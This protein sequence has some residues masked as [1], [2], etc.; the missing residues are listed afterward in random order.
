MPI[1]GFNNNK[2]TT[3]KMD[4]PASKWISRW[5]LARKDIPT[6]Q[7]SLNN[8]PS[9][10]YNQLDNMA[11]YKIVGY[12]P[13]DNDENETHG[14]TKYENGTVAYNGTQPQNIH[15]HE[16]THALSHNSPQLNYIKQMQKIGKDFY[17][18]DKG[19]LHDLWEDIWYGNTEEWNN[20]L[21]KPAEI[22]SRL[23]EI[24][25]LNNIDPKKVWTRDELNEF[26]KTAKDKNIFSEYNN[27]FILELFNNV[28]QNT[29]KPN[30][31]S[32]YAKQGLKI[33]KFGGKR[34]KTRT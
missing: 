13:R 20:Y 17:R 8:S 33:R 14:I 1:P 15:V 2:I 28:A 11:K 30:Q 24:R 25:Y 4:L 7:E 10:V 19:F 9:I 31:N 6:V 23:M 16:R 32:L 3:Y 22:Y 29:E 12:D 26:K 34:N 27:D 18:R 5:M 21:D